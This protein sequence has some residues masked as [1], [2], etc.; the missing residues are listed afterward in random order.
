MDEI[1]KGNLGEEFVNQLTY[2]SYLKYWCYPGPRDEY[3]D[4]KEIVDLLILFKN[5]CLL[6]SVKNY[7]FK[8]KYDKY[9]RKTL[10]KA[11]DQLYGAERKL[12]QSARP[13][14][15]KHPDRETEQFEPAQFVNVRR[16]IVNLGE[17]V[18]YYPFNTT[19]KGSKFVHVF[20]K[21]AFERIIGEMDTLPELVDYLE[22]REELFSTKRLL[23]FQARN[24]N[25]IWKRLSSFS[26]EIPKVTL[27]R[28]QNSFYQVLNQ[29]YPNQYDTTNSFLGALE[30]FL[31][32]NIPLPNL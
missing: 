1:D 21:A 24:K 13:I 11:T 16:V 30:L 14:F 32:I 23:C 19:T 2:K 18:Q 20:D 17:E 7:E 4:R 3:G 28:Y 29:T 9:F 25:L 6:I 5:I 8:G 27:P 22:K 10:T 15:F 26:I 31:S 12:Y